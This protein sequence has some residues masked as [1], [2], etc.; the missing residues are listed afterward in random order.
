M[1]NLSHNGTNGHGQDNGDVSGSASVQA[2]ESGPDTKLY[3]AT[4]MA[5]KLG[6]SRTQFYRF[7][8]KCVG[9]PTVQLPGMPTKYRLPEVVRWI[10]RNSKGGG[11]VDK[12]MKN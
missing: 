11:R 10:D 12:R 7:K 4:A 2:V 3:S 5:R 8:A 6:M 9:L 1:N